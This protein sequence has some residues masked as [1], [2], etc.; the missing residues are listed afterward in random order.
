L[1][2]RHVLIDF[3]EDADHTY[4][5]IAHSSLVCLRANLLQRVLLM[6]II[7]CFPLFLLSWNVRVVTIGSGSWRGCMM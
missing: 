4:P 3:L 7:D 1:L 5:L 2:L 6:D